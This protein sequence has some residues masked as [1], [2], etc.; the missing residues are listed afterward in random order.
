MQVSLY[1][2]DALIRRLDELA[3]RSGKSRSA[4]V[5]QLLE[6]AL[7]SGDESG[8]LALAGNWK[9]ARS[10]E[11]IIRE[12]TEGRRYNRRSEQLDR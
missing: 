7:V 9:D 5:Q 4:T 1:L 12:A 3:G 2:D 11:Q 10:A 6:G 8:L